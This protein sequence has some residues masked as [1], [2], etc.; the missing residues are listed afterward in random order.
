MLN[1]QTELNLREKAKK[2]ANQKIKNQNL[3]PVIISLIYFSCS[4]RF[5]FAYIQ[6]SKVFFPKLFLIKDLF[7]PQV[8]LLFGKSWLKFNSL[9][10]NIYNDVRCLFFGFALIE[11][12]S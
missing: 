9:D 1:M 3:I 5:R 11:C 2:L 10:K 12:F 4:D 8:R 7:L 6:N